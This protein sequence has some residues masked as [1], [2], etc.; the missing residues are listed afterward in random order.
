MAAIGILAA[1][2]RRQKTGLGT[3]IDMSMLDAL[4]YMSPIPLVSALARVGGASGEPR[5]EAFGGNPRYHLYMSADGRPVA[6][7][8][9]ETSAWVTF[10]QHIGRLDLIDKSELTADRLSVHGERRQRYEKALT[11]YCAGHTAKEIFETMEKMGIAV[12]PA[13][14]PDEALASENTRERGMLGFVDHPLEGRTPYLVNPLRRARLADAIQR[15]A[16]QLG[17]HSR[18]ILQE[19]GLTANEISKLRT[20]G[21]V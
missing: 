12:G 13:L 17:E 9:L 7:A 20:D 8:L 11:E 10:C 5:Q 16:P 4:M 15:P 14:S 21:I 18:E 2:A 6:V 19:L 3:D 1:L